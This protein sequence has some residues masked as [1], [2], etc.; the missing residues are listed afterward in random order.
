MSP[1]IPTLIVFLGLFLFVTLVGFFAARWRAGDLSRLEEWGLGGRRFGTWVTWFLLGGDL[2]TAYTFIA[3][4]A[5]MFGAGASGFFAVPYTILIYPILFLAFP[6]LW[7]VARKHGY[8]TAADFVRG[9][10]GHRGL[11]L[12][13]ALTGILATMPYIALQLVGMQVVIAALGIQSDWIIAGVTVPDVPLLAAFAVLAV[14]TY[15]SGLRAPALIAVVKDF[16]IYATVLAAIVVIPAELGGYGKLFAGVPAKQLLL[17]PAPAG[18]L[19]AQFAYGSLALGSALALFL[20]PHS[21][22]GLL[23]AS[24]RHAVRRNALILPAYSFALALI[25]LLGFMAI[26]AGVKTMPEYAAGFKTFGNNFAVPALILKSFP[27]WFAG[28]AFAAIAIGALVPAAIMS[29]ACA[30]LFTRNIYKEF[31]DPDCSGRRES[32][33]AKIVSLVVKVGALF[34]VLEMRS[35]YAIQLQLLGGIWICQTLPAVLIALYTRFFHPLALI[36]GWLAGLAVGTW[37][38]WT[39][40]FTTTYPLHLFGLT[41][42][43]YAALL[44]L[45]L[46]IAVALILTPLFNALAPSRADETV[47]ADYL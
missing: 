6:R 29:I 32:E 21:L 23:G 17:T 20:Y 15:S 37:M 33:V 47:A 1:Q 30:N 46:N 38:F 36:A 41:I 11:A 44:A 26:A 31:I 3:V 16:L 5:A 22:T 2:Y 10:F 7:S 18:S 42:P 12:T 24:S 13:V 28:L 40:N 35:T 27:A 43:T 14:Y 9:R 45:I 8:V 34:F 25:A 4:P 19:G 39:Q